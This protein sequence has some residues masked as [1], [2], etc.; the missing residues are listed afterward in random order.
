MLSRA[1]C[2]L[3]IGNSSFVG[4]DIILSLFCAVKEQ[5][6][7]FSF[8]LLEIRLHHFLTEVFFRSV[9]TADCQ[10]IFQF[11]LRTSGKLQIRTFFITNLLEYCGP[12]SYKYEVRHCKV[13]CKPAG[14]NILSG[15]LSH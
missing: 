9:R 12:E 7:I 1:L 13:H 4:V 8:L 6:E 11:H 2:E 10:C 14:Q 3:I 15:S 5:I